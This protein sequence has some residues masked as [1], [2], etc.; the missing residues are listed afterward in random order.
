MLLEHQGKRPTIHETAYVAPNAVI[1]GEVTVGAHTC[2]LF[3]AVIVAEAG[4]VEIGDSCVIMEHA[5]IRG[6]ARHPTRIGKHV[7]VGPRAYLTGC[8]VEDCVF[9]A[10]GA[11]VFNGARVGKRAEVRINGVVHLRTVIP[12]D[13]VVP[14]GWVAVG[15]PA[16]ILP[17]E[18]HER[19]WSIQERLDFPG[20]VFGLEREPPGET[21]MPELTRRYTRALS[22]HRADRVIARAEPGDN[23]D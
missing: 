6:T 22:A 23:V 7:L 21:L 11:T 5:V 3:S 8:T 9:L 12:P 17:P 18:E 16:A 19:I 20:F 1:C 4:P 10:T 13:A 2:I 15:G 14:I